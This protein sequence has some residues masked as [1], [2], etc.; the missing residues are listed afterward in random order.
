MFSR[1][2]QWES[3]SNRLTAILEARR[4]AGA[5]V[6]DLTLSNPTLCGF[7][8][9]EERILRA[10]SAPESMKYRP[11]P[12]GL[13]SAREAI[14]GYYSARGVDVPAE[15][16]F[17]TASTSESYS[18]LFRLLCNPED[19]VLIPTPSYP[20]FDYLAGIND[21]KT[22]YYR[23]VRGGRWSLDAA[24]LDRA[25]TK[26]VKA[27]LAVDPHNPTGMFLTPGERDEM[28]AVASG[29]G[30][31][32]IVDEVFGE[33]RFDG[34][35]V[36]AYPAETR[37]TAGL[38]FLLNGLSKMSALPQVKL[39]WIAL[40]GDHKLRVAARSRLEVLNDV[41][42]SAGTPAQVA[43]PELIDAGAGVRSQI[44]ER[45]TGNYAALRTALDGVAGCQV[46]PCEGGW[47]AVVR[48]PG[49]LGDEECAVGLL[50]EAGVYCYPGFFFDFEE[51]DVMVV[52][53]L[54]PAGE[55]SEGAAAMAG[56]IGA[57]SGRQG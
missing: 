34:A 47:N 52:S 4:S 2:T 23:L 20:L 50:D 5:R 14:S 10:L 19:S 8:Y 24:S 43:L 44:L 12:H 42:L 3:S 11:D 26:S 40:Q 17:I 35:G 27:V 18:L 13:M 36:A 9:P 51:D 38:T 7:Q 22:G 21:V 30:A 48:L 29:H 15:D 16:L 25:M 54:P 31:A 28:A 49:G 32:L 1:R 57:N 37:S 46:L 33:Y 45:M 55:F 41:F 6:I 53:L 39:G 56:W